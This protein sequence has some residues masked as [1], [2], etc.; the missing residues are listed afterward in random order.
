MTL[1]IDIFKLS[2]LTDISMFQVSDK[3]YSLLESMGD[4][5]PITNNPRLP[6][7]PAVVRDSDSNIPQIVRDSDSNIP[8]IVRDSDSNIPQPSLVEGGRSHNW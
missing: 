6:F 3:L 4:S 8:Q 5:L 7:F 1:N 2:S